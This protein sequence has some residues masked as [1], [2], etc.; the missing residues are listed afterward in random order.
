MLPLSSIKLSLHEG[1]TPLIELGTWSGS[2]VYLKDDSRN[3]TGSFKDRE[4]FVLVNKAVENKV[5]SLFCV[6][7]GNAALSLSAYAQL[8]NISCECFVS[9]N[10]S[11]IKKRLIKLY[12]GRISVLGSHYED[13][14]HKVMA[15]VQN[16]WNCCSGINP[17]NI[18]GGKTVAFE[19]WEEL[20]VPDKVI[21]PCGNG[22]NL[23]A[24]YKGF[25]E[26]KKIGKTTRIPKIIGVQV[27][28][29]D[30]LQKSLSNKAE[31]FAIPQI[32]D[33]IADSIVASESYS[34]PKALRALE[35]SN[36]SIVSVTDDEITEAMRSLA[37]CSL[38]IE[39]SSA[40][41]L[42]ALNHLTL[43]SGETIVCIITGSANKMLNQI[44]K[45]ITG[46]K[47][48]AV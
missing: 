27:K 6:S 34:A 17:Y 30:P 44:Y 16:G 14:Y 10:T 46:D 39:P 8:A 32:P 1:L 28:E 35:E 43:T 15:L 19:I 7:S 2:K 9:S 31:T 24:V 26:L 40:S 47:S 25:A 45:I 23:A 4:S 11:S 42:A 20:G 22:T 38:M 5:N 36:G 12:G 13:T 33:S 18:E 37:R 29:A 21:V 48:G 3:P 41:V